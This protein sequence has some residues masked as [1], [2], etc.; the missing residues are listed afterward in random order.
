MLA[1]Q[2]W[3]PMWAC[4]S[5]LQ[6]LA[7]F[8]Y[9]NGTTTGSISSSRAEKQRRAA[10]SLD[11]NLKNATFRKLFPDWVEEAERRKQLAEASHTTC[12][13]LCS[14]PYA[15]L[16]T[17]SFTALLRSACMSQLGCWISENLPQMQERA[18][19]PEPPVL[20]EGTDSPAGTGKGQPISYVTSVAILVLVGALLVL[21][22]LR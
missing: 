15:S 18:A 14:S 10:E 3:N 8:M 21:P 12:G 9:E 7:S 19:N 6:G 16:G 13:C 1:V 11:Y 20:P 4:S 22:F 2:S 5:I 17:R